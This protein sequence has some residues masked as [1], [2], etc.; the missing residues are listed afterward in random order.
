MPT[1]NLSN[2]VGGVPDAYEGHHLI[3]VAQAQKYDVMHY[4]ATNLKYNINRGSNGIALP[5]R[6]MSDADIIESKLPYHGGKHQPGYDALL[7]KRLTKLNDK[8]NAGLL[9]DSAITSG[10]ASIENQMRSNLKLDL[11]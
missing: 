10:I 6:T 2:I 9:D 3:S 7:N 1:D 4:A 5:G 8:F 11:N